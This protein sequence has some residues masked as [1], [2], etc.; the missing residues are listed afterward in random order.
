MSYRWSVEGYSSGC[1][2][3]FSARKVLH[4]TGNQPVGEMADT[5]EE[6]WEEDV[7]LSGINT[8]D[9]PPSHIVPLET[10][11]VRIALAHRTA[12]NRGCSE[13]TLNSCRKY[14]REMDLGMLNGQ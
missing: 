3:V 2:L 9:T 10:V 1:E 11:L 8:F 5:S 14:V 13:V 6:I 7:S 4:N 12:V